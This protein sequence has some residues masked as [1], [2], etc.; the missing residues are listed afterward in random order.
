MANL[1]YLLGVDE[2]F[3]PSHRFETSWILPPWVLFAVR[4]IISVYAFT[5]IFFIMGWEGTRNDI[6]DVR[7]SF[8]FFTYLSY[9]GLAFY[10]F[11]AAIHTFSYARTGQPYLSRWPRALQALH[12]IY[13]TSIV[14][15]PFLVTIV[16]WALLYTPPWFPIVFNAWQNVSLHAM[17]SLFAL[18][19]LLLTRTSPPPWLHLAILIIIL[20]LYV[21][22]AYITRATE[23]FYT[24]S[25]LNPA[26]HG[27]GR[28][29]AYVFGILAAIIVIFVVVWVVIWVRRR[30]TERRVGGVKPRS[31]V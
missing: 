15:L 19:E 27:S 26:T 11:V 16:F 1:Y 13:Y 9:W 5:V 21:G 8:S 24:Y 12:S 4:A 28:V 14:T 18:F 20:A 23:G 29:A 22:L 10:F 17:N 31:H 7:Q 6:T 25:F 2:P 3:D 30:I